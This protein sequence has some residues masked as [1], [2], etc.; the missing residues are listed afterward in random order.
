M[1]T[2]HGLRTIEMPTDKN[3]IYYSRKFKDVLIYFYKLFLRK[4]YFKKRYNEFLSLFNIAKN[5]HIFCPSEHTKYS[6]KRIYKNI[7]FNNLHVYYSPKKYIYHDSKSLIP[8]FNE[9]N[10]K[11]NKYFLMISG[12]RWIKNSYRMLKALDNL[13]T[14]KYLDSFKIVVLGVENDKMFN[15]L[16]NKKSFIFKPYVDYE[17]LEK[18]YSECFSFLYPSL[19]EGF[20]YPPLEAMKY[21]KPVITTSIS[22]INEICGNGVLYTNPYDIKEMENRILQL[23]NNKELYELISKNGHSRFKVVKKRQDSDL[24]KISYFILSKGSK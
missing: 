19:N 14:M 8:S 23:T 22:A 9:I 13:F 20:G 5:I 21:A 18:L 3:E 10:I 16:K 12:D 2:I 1:I 6:I 17:F 11:S 7:N 4:N 24:T 15:F